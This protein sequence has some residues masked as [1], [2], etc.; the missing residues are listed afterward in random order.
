MIIDYIYIYISNDIPI[1]VGIVPHN[2]NPTKGVEIPI[3]GLR[4]LVQPSPNVGIYNPT[5]DTKTIPIVWF[6]C[7]S[8]VFVLSL[9]GIYPLY[10]IIIFFYHCFMVPVG[11][12]QDLH[13][14]THVESPKSPAYSHL[15]SVTGIL[16]ISS[17]DDFRGK[18]MGIS[19]EYSRNI[20]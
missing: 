18:F 15:T 2:G 8:I 13:V 16:G 10:K 3:T 1:V 19:W 14:L 17:H 7:L 20:M 4:T 6:Q 5:F 11:K 12:P 9:Y